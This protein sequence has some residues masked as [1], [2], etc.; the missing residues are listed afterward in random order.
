MDVSSA[1]AL[2]VAK[3]EAG[4]AGGALAALAGGVA[5]IFS[6]RWK[7]QHEQTQRQEERTRDR[8]EGF[9]TAQTGYRRCYQNFLD[10]VAGFRS[11]PESQEPSKSALLVLFHRFD[12]ACLTGDPLV[13]EELVAYWPQDRRDAFQPPQKSPPDKL[14]R[15]MWEHGARS[16][17]N[18]DEIKQKT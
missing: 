8:E 18:Q 4:V 7:T 13:A 15:A 11:T 10:E 14:M 17:G 1:N 3:A 6:E 9:E 5:G 2:V 16:L 12:E